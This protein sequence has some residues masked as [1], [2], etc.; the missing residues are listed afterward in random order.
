MTD[1]IHKGAAELGELL[2]SGEVSAR[3]VTEAFLERI[4]QVDQQVHAF[5]RTD[6]E[7][8]LAAARRVD[9]ERAAGAEL[10]P[11]AGVPIALKDNIVTR[12]LETTA[13][14]RMLEHWVPPYDAT[15]V[16]KLR[17]AGMPILG[18]TNLD[19]F[20]M[21]SSTEFSAFGPTH[22]PWDLERIPGGSGGGSAAAV[23][24]FE[25]P[26]ALGSD[27]GGSIRQP[28]AMTGTVGIKPTYGAVSRYGAIALASSLDQIGPVARRVEDAAVLHSVIGGYDPAD[29]TSLHAPVPDFRAAARREDLRGVRVGVVK[30]LGGDGYQPGVRES[31]E[32]A[33]ELL[34]GLGAEIVTVS[35]PSFDYAMAAYYLILPAE[36][37]SNLA[38]FDGMKFGLR[39]E[40][41]DGPVTAERV[42]AATRGA[43]F[44]PE[45][46][47]RIILG[48][49]ALSAGYFDAYYGSA[50]KVRTLIQQD[51]A[52]AFQNVDVMVSP[53]TPTTAFRLGE[54]VDD[55]MA[56]YLNDL[57]TT[58]ANM[59]GVPAMSLPSGLSGDGLPVGFQIIAP[60]FED[61]R[62]YEVA[63]PLERALEAR[64][65]GALLDVHAGRIEAAVKGGAR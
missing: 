1:L 43:G 36:A 12:G 28:G 50:Q 58:P 18:K 14:S 51:F 6:P 40:P 4:G 16:R 55:L 26:L 39:V 44:G 59:A 10:G 49:H 65:G 33:L 54:K 48:T 24:A 47:R 7:G 5:L 23:A 3:Q 61:A 37:S 63:G 42:M 21:G 53:A 15:V 52:A 8:A 29:S 64:W 32:Q 45:V 38:R 56:M 27:T 46:K 31:F 11:L 30:E 17:A 57:A 2:A 41:A 20:A 9:E 60:A 22:N 13:A 19:E 25:A 62:M 35:C 34:A